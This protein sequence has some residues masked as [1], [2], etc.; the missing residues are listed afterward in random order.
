MLDFD[1]T[2]KARRKDAVIAGGLTLAALILFLLPAAY[3]RPIQHAIRDT[4]L[5]PFLSAQATIANR[6]ATSVDVS[7]LRAQRDSFAALLAAEATL[8]EEN[9][10]LR[11]LLGL[12][13]R[14]GSTFIPA[15]V[16][17]LGVSGA[18]STFMLNVGS[19][20]GVEVGSP[21]LAPEGLVGVVVDVQERN[22]QA[23]DWTH[24]DFRASAMTADGRAYGIVEPRRGRY[25][26][27][28]LLALTGAPFHSDL[29]PGTPI[30]TS[31]RGQVYPRGIPIGMV[32]GIEEADTGWRKSYLIRPAI[33]PEAVV[34]V[35]VGLDNEDNDVSRLWNTVLPPDTFHTDSA[36]APTTGER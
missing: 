36:P 24:P 34:H 13:E 23:M 25:R 27:E 4:A 31:G 14:A 2:R 30:V 19:A 32:L 11:A 8:A 10:R 35:L 17:R 18:E 16:L 21:V 3:Q 7:A 1:G 12:R 26:E 15:E 22:A 29:Q 6:R 20:Q 9:A 33:R 28:D 5:R